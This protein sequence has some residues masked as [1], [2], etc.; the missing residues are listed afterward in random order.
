MNEPE[1]LPPDIHPETALLPWL[2]NGTLEGAERSQLERHL[3]TCATCRAELNELKILQTKLTTFYNTQSGPSQNTARSVLNTVAGQS[4]IRTRA[5]FHRNSWFETVDD[6]F[7]SLLLPRW[8]PTL[9][10]LLLVSQLSILTWISLSDTP[11][12][13]ITSRSVGVPA[14][15]VVVA[16]QAA[17]TAKDIRSLLQTVRGRIIDGPTP[18]GVYTLEVLAVDQEVAHEKLEILR[19]R[20]DLVRSS[21][22]MSP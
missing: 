19:N 2:A 10:A 7:R 4:G 21:S 18:E 6:W 1:T 5:S 13:P 9:A 16:F 15:K 14:V 8:I 12:E 22:L 3:E 17:A 20:P 11:S